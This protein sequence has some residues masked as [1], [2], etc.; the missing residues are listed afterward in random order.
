MD[1]A[2]ESDTDREH[3]PLLHLVG[4][5][6][7]VPA[8]Y[9]SRPAAHPAQGPPAARLC[10]PARRRPPHLPA[11]AAAPPPPPV[12]APGGSPLRAVHRAP[13]PP[14]LR[15]V[16]GGGS[17]ATSAEIYF[18]PRPGSPDPLAQIAGLLGSETQS[19]V[20][21]LDPLRHAACGTAQAGAAHLRSSSAPPPRL[22]PPPP[23]APAPAPA[24]ATVRVISP[25]RAASPPPDPPRPAVL[26][27]EVAARVEQMVGERWAEVEGHVKR[28][29][30]EAVSKLPATAIA[31]LAEEGGMLGEA[32]GAARGMRA[33]LAAD[34]STQTEVTVERMRADATEMQTLRMQVESVARAAGAR[35]GIHD[36]ELDKARWDG[37]EG[38][39]K[40][41]NEASAA[42]ARAMAEM[43]NR[44]AELSEAR[45]A[46]VRIRDEVQQRAAALTGE[47]GQLRTMLDT[48]KDE[49]A[50]ARRDHARVS[51]EHAACPERHDAARARAAVAEAEV[52]RLRAEMAGLRDGAAL[53][54]QLAEQAA[55]H[56]LPQAAPQ[57]QEP[58]AAPM[59][60]HYRP[61]FDLSGRGDGAALDGRSGTT[62]QPGARPGPAAAAPGSSLPPGA[63]P[64]PAA[65]AAGGG[66]PGGCG[67][68]LP[69]LAQLHAAGYGA[70]QVRANAMHPAG[71]QCV[72]MH[73]PGGAPA[74][75]QGAAGDHGAGLAPGGAAPAVGSP[76]TTLHAPTPAA[77]LAQGAHGRGAH[78]GS[79]GGSRPPSPSPSGYGGSR[80]PSP[81]GGGGALPGGAGGGPAG[82]WAGT[83][84]PDGGG[85]GGGPPDVHPAT[86]DTSGASSPRAAP[87]WGTGAAAAAGGG[88]SGGATPEP[89]RAESARV[90]PRRK[91]SADPFPRPPLPGAP[92]A[93]GAAG[94]TPA[95][96]VG[97]GE[98][99]AAARRG[100]KGASRKPRGPKKY[101]SYAQFTCDDHVPG[102]PAPQKLFG[103]TPALRV[104]PLT[105]WE[106]WDREQ[107]TSRANLSPRLGNTRGRRQESVRAA[108][109]RRL[110]PQGE[111]KCHVRG[112]YA[113]RPMSPEAPSAGS[114]PAP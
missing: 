96:A 29:L 108:S 102:A 50:T 84:F 24:T 114:V 94:G 42:H 41:L 48:L 79:C 14:P 23:P 26:A 19:H 93:A 76:G 66:L 58:A 91:E 31:L 81:C 71:Q 34:A 13:D 15:G 22:Q 12:Y 11:G 59:P 64:A 74:A 55:Y 3:A 82:R 17:A 112:R 10:A 56:Q 86:A 57:Q 51:G 16:G 28:A 49:L 2:A 38:M 109:T 98:A 36:A 77:G 90:S 62:P 43:R 111:A 97:A 60:P 46:A 80:P 25:P 100:S 105:S 18:D 95:A 67:G 65:A 53:A 61:T 20:R 87:A 35:Q 21:A 45:E 7:F 52:A 88:G 27:P 99:A 78:T 6:N 89:P 1:P 104:P 83:A 113:D 68:A 75:P 54:R 72:G 5:S 85:G 73:R 30:A 103:A 4:S 63:P 106:Q 40:Q 9:L 44:C 69:T 47:A 70:G 107:V 92:A 32:V 101:S 37:A 33:A 8:A 110:G 39:R